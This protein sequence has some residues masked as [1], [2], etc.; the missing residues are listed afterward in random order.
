MGPDKY[1]KNYI[2]GALAP[3]GSGDYLDNLNPATAVVYSHFPDSDGSD[4]QRA[5]E[6]AERAFPAWSELESKKRFRL[7]IRIADI[8]EQQAEVFARAESLDTGKPLSMSKSVDVPGAYSH[9]RFFASAIPHFSGESFHR[10]GDSMTYS[11]RQPLGLVAC[12]SHWNLPLHQFTWKV[13]PALAMGNCVLA[14][15]SD[16]APMTAYL[17]SK[18]C[19]EAGLPPGVLN[20]VQGQD[21]K[22]LETM[23]THPKVKAVSFSGNLKKGQQ[24]AAWAN[25]SFKKLSLQLGGKNANII[26]E[27][28]SFNQMLL[29]TLRSSFSNNG[30]L[31]ES[32]SRIFIERSLYERFREEFVKRTQ[33]LKIGDPFSSVTDLGAL[34]SREHMERVL[35]YIAL[36]EMEGGKVLCGGTPMEMEN[37]FEEGFFIRPAIIEGL[38][39]TSRCMREEIFGPVVF[40]APFD[41]EEEAIELANENN[42]CHSASIWTQDAE[43]IKRVSAGLDAHNIWVNCWNV[44]DLSVPMSHSQ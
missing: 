10:A 31:I 43:R 4:V 22:L 41:T 23:I 26:F 16:L 20:I 7:L 21:E 40:I 30:Q 44:R 1:I 38:S 17:F 29:G 13:A 11:F 8:I 9:F 14:K 24:V 34:I 28:C 6:A 33:F 36:A 25:P 3:A 42:Y 5:V 15:P 2:A 27:D 19:L 39:H 35:S 37:E 12:I 32:G 18:A